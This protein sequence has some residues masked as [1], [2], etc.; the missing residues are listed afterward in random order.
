M[1]C[2]NTYILGKG[3]RKKRKEG[4][5]EILIS[6]L[7]KESMKMHYLLDVFAGLC[8]YSKVYHSR[9]TIFRMHVFPK[10]FMSLFRLLLPS[11]KMYSQGCID[12]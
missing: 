5:R 6:I 9:H 1:R 3:L 2:Y 10:G 11:S 12:F 4:G 8:H 7:L